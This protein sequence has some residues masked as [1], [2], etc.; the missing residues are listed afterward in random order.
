MATWTEF[1]RA[2]F[3]SD[4]GGDGG[5]G[6]SGGSGGANGDD[7]T[8]AV[9]APKEKGKNKHGKKARLGRNAYKDA[10]QE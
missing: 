10:M 6:G 4:G 7:V 8:S 2:E 3:Y 1:E 5:D 9:A